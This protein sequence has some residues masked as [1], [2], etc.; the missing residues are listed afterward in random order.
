MKSVI[1][2]AEKLGIDTDKIPYELL[3]P[4]AIP[5]ENQQ[6][7]QIRIL[8]SLKGKQDRIVCFQGSVDRNNLF[9]LDDILGYRE[10][11]LIA[12][13]DGEMRYIN[14]EKARL[15]FRGEPAPTPIDKPNEPSLSQ[16]SIYSRPSQAKYSKKLEAAMDEAEERFDGKKDKVVYSLRQMGLDVTEDKREEKNSQYIDVHL[17]N[18]STIYVRVSNHPAKT[19]IDVSIEKDWKA[20]TRFICEQADRG[21]WGTSTNPN[22]QGDARWS[23]SLEEEGEKPYDGRFGKAARKYQRRRARMQKGLGKPMRKWGAARYKKRKPR[24]LRL[25]RVT[26]RKWFSEQDL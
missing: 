1:E 11:R 16:S 22:W 15:P 2:Q 8:T 9:V 10:D 18:G 17:D 12:E 13:L 4:V 21:D 26:R 7:K 14:K 19:R 24:S 20:G 6:I 25:N 3:R 23:F 5:R